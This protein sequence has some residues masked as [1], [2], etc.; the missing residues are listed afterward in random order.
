MFNVH[1]QLKMYDYDYPVQIPYDEEIKSA[2]KSGL[3]YYDPIKKVF[4]VTFKGELS[5]YKHQ[6]FL[7]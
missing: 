2:I 4:I 3:I 1:S 6:K 5:L 7:I